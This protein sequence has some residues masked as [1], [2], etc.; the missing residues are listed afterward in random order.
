MERVRA[1]VYVDDSRTGKVDS[2]HETDVYLVEF[3]RFP[4]KMMAYRS[5]VIDSDGN[6]KRRGGNYAWQISDYKKG[7]CATNL[8]VSIFQQH[9]KRRLD[10]IDMMWRFVQRLSDEQIAEGIR[11]SQQEM[12]NMPDIN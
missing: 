5:L 1:N 8:L 10:V 11:E 2:T 9:T 6:L 4:L 12:D 3:D 7:L